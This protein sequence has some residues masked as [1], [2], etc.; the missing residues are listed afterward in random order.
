MTSERRYFTANLQSQQNQQQNLNQNQA[1]NC[2]LCKSSSR[3]DT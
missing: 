1:L 3:I 2:L